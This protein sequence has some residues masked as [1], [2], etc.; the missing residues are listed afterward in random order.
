MVSVT[1]V[2]SGLD[3]ESLVTQLLTAERAPTETRLARRE[4]ALTSE[5]SAFGTLKG[6]LAGLQGR[7]SALKN[8]S[9]FSQ[10]SAS[11][12]NSEAVSASAAANAAVG[13]YSL[14]VSAKASAQTL[15][16]G[17]F[18]SK[19]E[20]V[21][22]GV[23]SIRFG[24]LSATPLEPGPQQVTGFTEN[25]QR[26]G[27]SITIDGS[28]NTLE[29]IRDAVNGSGLGITASVV[30]DGS[31]YRLLFTGPDTGAANGIEIAVSDQGD[32]NN[33]DAQ[34]LS[35]LAFNTSAA[36]LSQTRA[37]EDAQFTLNGLALS[38]ASNT[39][40]DVIEG[41]TLT[42]GAVTEQDVNITVSENRAAVRGAVEQL[43]TAYNSFIS[44]A[45]TL[46][47]YEPATRL[48]GP[49]QGDSGTRSIISQVRAALTDSVRGAEG[50][51]G[52]LA[53]LGITTAEDGKLSIDSER[54]NEVLDDGVE[55]FGDLFTR[56][57]GNGIA[58]R[59]DS[60]LGGF[61]GATGLIQSREDGL[62]TR[63]EFIN[64]DREQLNQRLEQLEARYR[65]QF[66]AL[67]GLLAQLN[68]T[69]SFVAEQLANIPLPS[70][71]FSN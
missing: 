59:L 20:A 67:D 22:E 7:A 49:L 36:N 10:R 45:A 57:E 31:S 54:L 16:S 6:L 58:Q 68:S 64:T 70:D 28:N 44:S 38:S 12:S 18:S 42:L 53:E 33:T 56:S 63:I 47:R 51:F 26:A 23:L 60:L 37:A 29:G 46:T 35:R 32:S 3:I 14:S 65:A 11:S 50:P 52:S 34:G 27:A 25:T 30:K 2:G 5:L 66:N 21:G 55:A 41:V 13:S 61:L 9:T 39:V 48:A 19:T 24:S 4:A 40:T 62:E 71:R 8:P 15:A 43:V 1:G 17:A 69:G